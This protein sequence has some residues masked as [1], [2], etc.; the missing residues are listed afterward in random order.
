MR[1]AQTGAVLIFVL[2]SLAIILLGSAALLTSSASTINTTNNKAYKLAATSVAEVAVADAMSYI[3]SQSLPASQISVPNLYSAQ[4][5]PV[6]A[7]RIPVVSYDTTQP[8][9]PSCLFS[10]LNPCVRG[11]YSTTY[12]IERMCSDVSL[13]S[14]TNCHVTESQDT[15]SS[16]KDVITKTNVAYRVTVWVN[17]PKGTN[18]VTQT[19][20]FV[21][22]LLS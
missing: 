11:A 14:P 5:L 1:K 18:T 3:N 10:G 9:N 15:S 6:D 20:F 22:D 2:I 8:L 13:A 12:I 7:H 19:E 4:M 21:S 17:G 16:V